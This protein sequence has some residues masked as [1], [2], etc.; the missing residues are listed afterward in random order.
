MEGMLTMMNGTMS[1][2]LRRAPALGLALAIGVLGSARAHATQ[3]AQEINQTCA[4]LTG[5]FDGDTA[6]W[7]V[8]IDASSGTSFVLTSELVVPN[9]NTGAI[10]IDFTASGVTLDLNGFEIT[11]VACLHG[12]CVPPEGATGVGIFADPTESPRGIVV[13]DGIVAGL[14][15]HGIQLGEQAHVLDM[16]VRIEPQAESPSR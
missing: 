9:S 4:T 16:R 11:N 2:F 12:D 15:S 13:R 7:P 8:T 6:G 5:C 10:S 14:G 1:C 3:G